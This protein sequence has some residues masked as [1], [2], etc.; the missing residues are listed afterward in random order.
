MVEGLIFLLP[1]GS[2]AGYPMYESKSPQS[3][4]A[5]S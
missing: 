1:T 2:D 5:D 4:L 3:S